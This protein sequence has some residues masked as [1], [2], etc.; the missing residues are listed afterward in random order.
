MVTVTV[1]TQ[2][3]SDP[4]FCRTISFTYGITEPCL[5]AKAQQ[6][7]L[8]HAF[9]GP[10]GLLAMSFPSGKEVSKAKKTCVLGNHALLSRSD[11]KL[12]ITPES[13]AL[14]VSSLQR[15]T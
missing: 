14:K 11:S 8:H 6:L 7:V 9:Q 13:L 5:K 4:V 2:S 15:L 1:S 12:T 10:S 3:G